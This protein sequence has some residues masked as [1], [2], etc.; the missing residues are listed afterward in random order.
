MKEKRNKWIGLLVM[1]M[2]LLSA[3]GKEG[4]VK[5]ANEMNFP[6]E[7]ISDLVIS[8]D[9]ENIRFFKNE[10]ENLVIREYMSKDKERYHARVN[11]KNGSIRISEGGKPFFH[12]NFVRYVEVYLPVSYCENIEV[13]TTDGSID[14]SGMELSMKTICIET[15]SGALNLGTLIG[16]RINIETTRGNVTC[17]KIDG[18]V[19][20][21]STSGNA[22]FLS[23]KGSG[24]YKADNSGILSV[25]YDD[26][27]GDLNFFN[28]NGSIQIWLPKDLA[29]EFEAITKN[30]SIDTNFQ[31]D[32]SVNGDSARGTVGI[33][34]LVTV[35]LE[36]K[37]GD[38][39]VNR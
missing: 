1:M 20:Y 5:M 27:T 33:E 11:Q 17:E 9:D 19:T 39:E 13:T 7:N 12:R 37:N 15:T 3:C 34:P 31:G 29:F 8:Y 28:K 6:L 4:A 14:M 24:S 26:V 16:D 25:I 36:T 10:N 35:S 23:A 2:F 32:I 22:K 18:E 21:T 38:I 30:G